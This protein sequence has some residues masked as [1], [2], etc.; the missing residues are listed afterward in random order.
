M[1][2]LRLKIEQ[3]EAVRGGAYDDTYCL[4][5]PASL[6]RHGSK[7]QLPLP[8]RK[9]A[10]DYYGH[11]CL[12]FGAGDVSPAGWLPELRKVRGMRLMLLDHQA[13]QALFLPAAGC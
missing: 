8:L 2:Q 5:F 6:L 4:H 9:L 3:P 10:L 1:G 7:P 13:A 11:V 12:D